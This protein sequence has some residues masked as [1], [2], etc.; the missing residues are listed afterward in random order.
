MKYPPTEKYDETGYAPP[1]KPGD[2][3]IQISAIKEEDK[4]GKPYKDKNGFLYCLFEFAVKD[5]RGNKLFDRFCFD[6]N[7]PNLNI[8]MGRFKQLQIACGIDTTQEGDTKDMIGKVCKAYVKTTE[9]EG[10]INNRIGEYKD[11][12]EEFP[13][14]EF[15]DDGPPPHGDDD[16][17]F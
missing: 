8:N 4:N 16:L 2:Y 17:P 14:E 3:V 6:E 1:L 11:T 10:K 15:P 5:H 7:N 12:V 9:Y 13:D